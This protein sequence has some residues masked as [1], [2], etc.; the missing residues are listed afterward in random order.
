MWI[1]WTFHFVPG[2]PPAHKCLWTGEE[3][4]DKD[5]AVIPK[6]FACEDLP[7]GDQV[8][9]WH[10]FPLVHLHEKIQGNFIPETSG[11]WMWIGTTGL[12][13]YFVE[14]CQKNPN[15][16]KKNI[17]RICE[18][19]PVSQLIVRWQRLSW[20]QV[21]NC[22]YCNQCLKC[23]KS[24][25][26]LLLGCS[27]MEVHRKVGRLRWVGRS[28]GQVMSPHHSDQMSQVSRIALWL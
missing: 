27:L 12:S 1:R 23:H 21:L 13:L 14:R 26:S 17:A 28:F 6:R 18:C 9:M 16:Y 19:C 22:Q 3:V 11:L 5:H 7:Q 4:I 20:I 2:K 10:L 25:W 24:L 8:G 15:N